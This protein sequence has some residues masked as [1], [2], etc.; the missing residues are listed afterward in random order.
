MCCVCSK[1]HILYSQMCSLPA[2]L[3]TYTNCYELFSKRVHTHTTSVYLTLKLLVSTKCCCD[4]H[5]KNHRHL[6]VVGS[7]T[8]HT[9]VLAHMESRGCWGGGL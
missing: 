4:N 9:L 8:L 6:H 7:H 3:A 1:Q 5:K 2:N